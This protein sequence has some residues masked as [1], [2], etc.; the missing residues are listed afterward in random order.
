[1]GKDLRASAKRW[2]AI[3]RQ[4]PVLPPKGASSGRGSG[5]GSAGKADALSHGIKW[6]PFSSASSLSSSSLAS[7][8]ALLSGRGPPQELH[9]RFEGGHGND[10]NGY[11]DG[12]SD[13][14]VGSGAEGSEVVYRPFISNERRRLVALH[15]E[16]TLR[17]QVKKKHGRASFTPTATK[18]HVLRSSGAPFYVDFYFVRFLFTLC[19][20]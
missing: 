9:A 3:E 4:Q 12:S 16:A 8:A 10:Y 13:S 7:A 2:T 1:M 18:Y 14:H 20:S 6:W 15:G 17:W 19:V 5:G 11:D